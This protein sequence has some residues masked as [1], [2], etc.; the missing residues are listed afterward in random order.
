MAD[1]L[2][3]NAESANTNTTVAAD[4]LFIAAS[5][6]ENFLVHQ[7]TMHLVC[8]KLAMDRMSLI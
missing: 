6:G 3:K 5:L 1:A 2:T 8:Q 7:P 4:I